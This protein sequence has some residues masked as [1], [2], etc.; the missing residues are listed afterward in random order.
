MGGIWG[1]LSCG[2]F[3]TRRSPSRTASARPAC[4]TAAAL[5]QLGVQALGIAAV[6]AFV[7]TLERRVFYACKK[8]IGLRVTAQQELEGL[9]IHEHGMWGYPEQF[10]PGYGAT[11]PYVLAPSQ[12]PQRAPSPSRPRDGRGG[13]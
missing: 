1:T 3:T 7:F 5:H 13:D 4:S 12:R 9:D 6:S 2:L 8:T 11:Q 10:L